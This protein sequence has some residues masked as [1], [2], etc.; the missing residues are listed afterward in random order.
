[1]ISHV[2][3]RILWIIESLNA[4]GTLGTSWE[5]AR[6]SVGLRYIP[7]NSTPLGGEDVDGGSFV[8]KRSAKVITPQCLVCHNFASVEQEEW[9]RGFFFS[10]WWL[11]ILLRG[12]LPVHLFLVFHSSFFLLK[13]KGLGWLRRIKTNTLLGLGQHNMMHMLK[14]NILD[15][16]SGK[17]TRRI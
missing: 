5:R 14:K 9:W 6:S 15:L 7:S 11:K 16:E 12:D 1:M 10:P 8:Y 13:K 2:N 17:I 3:C 4:N